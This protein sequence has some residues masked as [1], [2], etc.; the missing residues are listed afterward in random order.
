M[1]AAE[2]VHFDAI[3]HVYKWFDNRYT[4]L[5]KTRHFYIYM[6]HEYQLD[7]LVSGRGSDCQK[8]ISLYLILAKTPPIH[9]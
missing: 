2:Y 7:F 5:K 3:K 8:E 1:T 4:H 9:Y 6:N